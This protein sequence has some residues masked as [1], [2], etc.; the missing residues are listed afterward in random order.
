MANSPDS[1]INTSALKAPGGFN[2]GD[3]PTASRSGDPAPANPPKKERTTPQRFPSLSLNTNVDPIP[4]IVVTGGFLPFFLP[5]TT[6][7]STAFAR[8][9]WVSKPASS[10]PQGRQFPALNLPSNT[11]TSASILALRHPNFR[12]HSCLE[13]LTVW[14]LKTIDFAPAFAPQNLDVWALNATDFR[15]HS[16]TVWALKTVD[17]PPAFNTPRTTIAPLFLPAMTTN[18]VT[19]SASRTTILAASRAGIHAA[20]RPRT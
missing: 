5:S 2:H 18:S 9:F 12:Q 4:S 7:F 15:Q 16:F 17:F 13:D 1:I 19:I 20:F 6:S 14:A 10:G 8:G 3:T 11:P